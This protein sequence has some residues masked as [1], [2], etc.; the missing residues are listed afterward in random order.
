MARTDW[1]VCDSCGEVDLTTRD[2]DNGNRE[3]DACWRS[4]LEHGHLH[5]LHQNLDGEAE[6]V[7]GCPL[8]PVTR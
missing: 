4:A 1:T 8:C 2:R 5:G 3:C 6:F 7:V